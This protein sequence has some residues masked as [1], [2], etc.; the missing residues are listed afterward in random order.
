MGGYRDIARA[1]KADGILL[2][3]CYLPYY[4]GPTQPDQLAFFH[5]L[6]AVFPEQWGPQ[7]ARVFDDYRLF[8][9][10]LHLNRAGA[11]E[12]TGNLAEWIVA[13]WAE[14]WRGNAMRPPR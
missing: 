3:F 4:K 9:D 1:A 10:S 14:P 2:V 6:G 11:A 8:S 13:E 12:E 5:G 7:E